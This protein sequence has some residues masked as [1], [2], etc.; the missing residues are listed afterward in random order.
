[1]VMKS[2]RL[3]KRPFRDNPASHMH[4]AALPRT[5]LFPPSHSITRVVPKHVAKTAVYH[6]ATLSPSYACAKK[7]PRSFTNHLATWSP[8]NDCHKAGPILER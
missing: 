5:W 3:T 8:H 1:V 2:G 6:Q 7:Q 4:Q